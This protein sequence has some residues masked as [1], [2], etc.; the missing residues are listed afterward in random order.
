[1]SK[2]PCDKNVIGA[3]FALGGMVIT[4]AAAMIIHLLHDYWPGITKL[5]VSTDFW[6]GAVATMALLMGGACLIA[7]ADYY[8]NKRWPPQ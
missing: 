8:G 2:K 5:L 4:L 3:A 1:M 7:L 6:I